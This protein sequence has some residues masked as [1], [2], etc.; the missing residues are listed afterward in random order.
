MGPPLAVDM[1]LPLADLQLTLFKV[2]ILLVLVLTSAKTVLSLP[3]TAP[4]LVS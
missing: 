3:K 2:G 4:S 1:L